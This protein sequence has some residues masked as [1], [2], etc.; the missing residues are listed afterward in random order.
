MNSQKKRLGFNPRSNSQ[1]KFS[2]HNASWGGS[3]QTNPLTIICNLCKITPGKFQKN[4]LA[5]NQTLTRSRVTHEG[6][7][8]Q[9]EETERSMSAEH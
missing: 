7:G 4:I 5:T 1:N 2:L 8:S 3:K 6:E 9:A